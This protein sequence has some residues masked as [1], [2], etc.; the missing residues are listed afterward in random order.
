MNTTQHAIATLTRTRKTANDLLNGFPEDKATYQPAPAVNHALWQVG[1]LAAT[2]DWY[3]SKLDDQGIT[4]SEENAA[5][6]GYGS[7]IQPADAYPAFDEVKTLL[8]PTRERLIAAV[9]AATDEKLAEHC[10][11]LETTLLGGLFALASHEGWHLGQL[12]IIRRSLD[13]PSIYA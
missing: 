1:H 9:E 11:E 3:A 5:L 13:L 10:A 7:T 4:L 6:F 2:D 8:A 12:S